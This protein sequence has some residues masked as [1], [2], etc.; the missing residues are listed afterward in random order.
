[1]RNPPLFV[2]VDAPPFTSTSASPPCRYF[3][4]FQYSESKLSS[5]VKASLL[6][7]LGLI[8]QY[9]PTT[10]AKDVEQLIKILVRVVD[11]ELFQ[12]KKK[13]ELTLA[14]GGIK[15]LDSI[16]FSFGDLGDEGISTPPPT[17]NPLEKRLN[18]FRF[19]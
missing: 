8:A 12:T 17:S 16:L 3:E 18:F 19:F 14:A 13:P 6:Q 1:M 15:S 9:Y 2:T 10:V 5:S 11:H 4:E 7:L